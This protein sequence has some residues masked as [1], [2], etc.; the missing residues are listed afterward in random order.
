MNNPYLNAFRFEESEDWLVEDDQYVLL[1]NESI[2][3]Q[4]TEDGYGVNFDKEDAI[5]MR[6]LRASLAAAM[7]EAI[8]LNHT[9]K[10]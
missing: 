1:A 7:R 4:V 9:M 10:S 8:N 5:V 6:P 3:V 2:R